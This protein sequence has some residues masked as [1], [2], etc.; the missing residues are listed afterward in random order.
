MK[1]GNN[2]ALAAVGDILG[3]LCR[4]SQSFLEAGYFS[5]V[6]HGLIAA[7]KGE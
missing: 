1:I 7:A 6:E 3:F 4:T 2:K 5:F